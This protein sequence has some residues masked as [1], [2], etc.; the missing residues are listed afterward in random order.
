MRLRTVLVLAAVLMLCAAND[1]FAQRGGGRGFGGVSK[2]GLLRVE[3]IQEEINL[4]DEQQEQV[5]AARRELRTER[6]GQGGGGQSFRDLSDEERQEFRARMAERAQ[7]RAKAENEKLAEILE[8]KQMKRLG[9]IYIQV[10]GAEALENAE[11]V[12]ALKISEE[13]QEKLETARDEARDKQRESMRD[14][15]QAGDREAAREKMA[16]L[17]KETDAIILAVLTDEQK[18]EFEQMKGESLEL[19]QDDLGRAR[20]F[21]GGRGRGGQQD[22]DA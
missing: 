1:A 22:D 5:R 21:G 15:F 3:K 9:E 13:Q 4:T 12:A 17:R 16:E 8:D 2:M 6:D 19:T 14:L 7:Q 18:Q 11:V 20:G 10:V